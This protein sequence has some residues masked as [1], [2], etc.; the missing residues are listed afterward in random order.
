MCGI[1]GSVHGPVIMPSA[2]FTISKAITM[3]KVGLTNPKEIM[4]PKAVTN[5]NVDTQVPMQVHES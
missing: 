2:R 1:Q 3:P 4:D 5:P